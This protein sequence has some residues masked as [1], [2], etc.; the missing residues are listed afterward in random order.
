M[1]AIHSLTC[2]N[3][4]MHNQMR[5]PSECLPT[6]DAFMRLQPCNN[7]IGTQSLKLIL[8]FGSMAMGWIRTCVR[9]RVFNHIILNSKAFTTV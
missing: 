3:S 9:I 2:V 6:L 5:P 4:M 1:D 8:S 7:E